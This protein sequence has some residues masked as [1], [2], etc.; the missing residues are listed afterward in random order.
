MIYPWCTG[1]YTA[2]SRSCASARTTTP[3]LVDLVTHNFHYQTLSLA[4][5]GLDQRQPDAPNRMLL[6][7]PR[8]GHTVRGVENID[9][10]VTLKVARLVRGQ[11]SQQAV[12]NAMG[13]SLHRYGSIERGYLEPRP[14]EIAKLA[15]VLGIEA[16]RMFRKEATA[17]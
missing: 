6:T 4:V 17:A 16:V 1:A 8:S 2:T 11:L 3:P 10:L 14:D 5:S 9:P 12:A 7:L 13:V 15:L